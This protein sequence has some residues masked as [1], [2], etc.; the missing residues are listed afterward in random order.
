MD[1]T[2]RTAVTQGLCLSRYKSPPR[3]FVLLK[4]LASIWERWKSRRVCS[5]LWIKKRYRASQP[6]VEIAGLIELSEKNITRVM[7]PIYQLFPPVRT[8]MCTLVCMRFFILRFGCE[9]VII[10][11]C[12]HIHCT[13]KQLSFLPFSDCLILFCLHNVLLFEGRTILHDPIFANIQK[14]L[15]YEH[16]L[17]QV[18]HY[19]V[20]KDHCTLKG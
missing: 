3:C 19:V 18:L 9:P 1:V 14:Y 13:C 16:L 12:G 6:L 10:S 8:C 15:L 7:R 20:W 2:W 11:T 5:L 17:V 4:W